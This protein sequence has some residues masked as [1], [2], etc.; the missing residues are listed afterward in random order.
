VDALKEELFGPCPVGA[1]IDTSRPITF[2]NREHAYGPWV[3]EASGE[4]ILQRDPPTRRYGIG[5]LYPPRTIRSE[6]DDG[7]SNADHDPDQQGLILPYGKNARARSPG[8]EP[9]DDDDLEISSANT[10]NP[11]SMALTFLVAPR[12]VATLSICLTGGRYRKLEVE[13]ADATWSW[14]VR[15]SVQIE[16]T[17]D[18]PLLRR[19]SAPIR[20]EFSIQETEE[21]AIRFAGYVRPRENGTALVTVAAV[22]V[23]TQGERDEWSLFQTRFEV[24]VSKQ[25][26][27]GAILPYPRPMVGAVDEVVH[28]QHVALRA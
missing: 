5:V 19:G 13:V 6:V 27:C 14:W 20:L 10:H 8:T 1:P 17:A 12:D 9:A 26:G 18:L 3:D 11:S 15:R 16:A 2:V 4:E 21:E 22:N 24:L 7:P 28:R 25:D 23:A